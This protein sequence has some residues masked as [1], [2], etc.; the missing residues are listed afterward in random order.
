MAGSDETRAPFLE[1]VTFE[2]GDESPFAI[3]SLTLHRAKLV[4]GKA[5]RRTVV[6]RFGSASHRPLTAGYALAHLGKLGGAIAD[7]E[8]FKLSPTFLPSTGA[9]SSFGF[10]L[11]TA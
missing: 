7:P 1:G 2:P 5:D 9:N 6:Q 10:E 3:P 11:D 8:P 4:V